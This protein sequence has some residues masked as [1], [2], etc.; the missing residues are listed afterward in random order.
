M[1]ALA[2][3]YSLLPTFA[4]SNGISANSGKII[5]IN[6]HKRTTNDMSHETLELNEFFRIIRVTISMEILI[7]RNE[8]SI[9]TMTENKHGW[10]NLKKF[11]SSF[12]LVFCFWSD[13]HS[14]LLSLHFFLFHFFCFASTSF[15]C[16]L[17]FFCI[18]SFLVFYL[19]FASTPYTSSIDSL[20]HWRYTH[21]HYKTYTHL[22]DD[23]GLNV[24]HNYRSIAFLTL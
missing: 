2:T 5:K 1:G 12:S 13:T 23:S 10:E 24:V 22:C 18:S 7:D 4:N 21:P 11:P 20:S 17:I 6:R 14:C 3:F 15:Q 16:F 8:N 9:T 19:V